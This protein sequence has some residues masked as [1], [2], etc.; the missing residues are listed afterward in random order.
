MPRHADV[1]VRRARMV[2]A[3]LLLTAAPATAQDVA[4]AT[5]PVATYSIVARDPVTGEM[6][7]A[8]RSHWFSVGPVVPWGRAG[9]GA[10][11]TQSFTNIAHGPDGLDLME[12]GLPPEEALARLIDGDEGRA[13]R[14]VALLD[15]R[16][17]TAAWTGERCIAEAGHRTGENYSVQAN[18]MERA[19]VPDAMVAAFT[20]AQGDLAARMLAA[21]A[22][23]EAE[24]GDIRGRQSAAIVVVRGE[25]TGR[26]WA[27]RLVDLRVEDHPDP[28]TEL[29]R[30]LTLR[31]AYALMDAGD[32]ALAAGD[33]EGA[34]Q[35]YSAA[36]SVAPSAY[37]TG[38]WA[39][40]TLAGTGREAEAL[41]F[42]RSAYAAEPRLRQ[43]VSRLPAAG[44][45]P[46]DDELVARLVS[47]GDD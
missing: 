1:T 42:L 40:I 16:G 34:L 15:A 47:A 25:S 35:Q 7:V 17:R 29:A 27:D 36:A 22:A 10:V 28:V 12:Q 31:K 20:S 26:V 3:A 21:L 46:D 14:Q 45:L 19:S 13:E 41:P 39:G 8:V 30:L 44:L 33:I 6:G 9:V 37:E 18:L 24:G 38:F 5:R 43:L 4:S 2:L 23:A 11:A 32:R